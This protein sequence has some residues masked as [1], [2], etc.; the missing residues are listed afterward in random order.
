MTDLCGSRIESLF[1]FVRF[2]FLRRW[3]LITPALFSQPPPRPPGE[4]GEVCL[5]KK[6]EQSCLQALSLP[7][8]GGEAGRERV[9]R[10]RVRPEGAR[11]TLGRAN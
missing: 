1:Y 2:P 11:T 3:A 4:E 6:Q 7:A 5:K 10:V 9:G 8:E